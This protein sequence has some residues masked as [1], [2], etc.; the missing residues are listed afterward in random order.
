MSDLMTFD[1]EM[2][3]TDIERIAVDWV[4]KFTEVVRDTDT[5]GLAK[6]FSSNPYWRDILVTGWD[7]RTHH[8]LEAVEKAFSEGAT[9]AGLETLRLQVGSAPALVE[10]AE[11]TWIQAFLQYES[12]SKTG[13]GVVRLVQEKPGE[14]TAWTFMTALDTIKGC[15]PA[16]GFNRPLGKDGETTPKTWLDRRAGEKDFADGDPTVVIVG[17]GQ[18]GL[19]LAANLRLLGVSTLVVEKNERVGDNWRQRYDS[20]VLH[21]PVWADHLPYF[22][23]PDSW[24][25]YTPKDKL[26]NW[27]EMYAETMELNVWTSARLSSSTY[28]ESAGQW[29][30]A[31][32]RADGSSR[33]LQSRHLVMATGVLGEGIMPAVAGME[34]FEGT[35]YHSSNHADA[36][37][38]RGKKVAVVGASV[39]GHDIARDFAVNGAEVTLVQRS[40]TYVMS[41]K[42]GVPVM[43]GDLYKEG[44]PPLAEADLLQSSFPMKLVLEFAK[45]NTERIAE[46]DREMLDGLEKAGFSL[47][48]GPNGGGLM[49]L[50]YTRGGGYYT[51]VGAS[52]LIVDG[53]IKVAS[54][55]GLAGF[56]KHGIVLE[57]G[58]EIDADIVVLATGF[59]SMRDRARTLFGDS[60]ADRCSEV[61][62]LDDE[63]EIRGLYRPSGHPNFWFMGGPLLGA[64]IYSKYLA[65]QI[66]GTELGL[67]HHNELEDKNA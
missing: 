6:V 13:V 53:T 40:S 51:D 32:T 27:F 64:R 18:G 21:D 16:T 44:G 57:D 50:A 5:Y 19:A 46:M 39:S 54:G 17:A 3:Q 59:S 8:G 63:G 43:F 20:L 10:A 34:E 60:V 7:L 9:A 37:D 49:E 28:D 2:T 45:G 42:N 47:A 11:G 55:S 30:L 4:A 12:D 56:S 66:L 38:A 36:T 1:L 52:A 65:L 61:W 58:T 48:W 22:P 41:Q 14:W 23:F 31:V 29:T 67:N 62:G 33:V 35:Y 15:E 26:G 24:P 25:I